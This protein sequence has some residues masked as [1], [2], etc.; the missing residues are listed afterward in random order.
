M[1]FLLDSHQ[2]GYLFIKDKIKKEEIYK[3]VRK[4]GDWTIYKCMVLSYCASGEGR[5]HHK[6]LCRFTENLILWLLM[7]HIHCQE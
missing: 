5:W 6:G 3:K 4:G 2:G 7:M 1:Q